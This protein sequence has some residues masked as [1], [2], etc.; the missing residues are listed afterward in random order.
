MASL[1]QTKGHI[2]NLNS[3]K[4]ELVA[5]SV[6]SFQQQEEPNYEGKPAQLLKSPDHTLS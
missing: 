5:A 1:A 6:K 4:P 3:S 2:H